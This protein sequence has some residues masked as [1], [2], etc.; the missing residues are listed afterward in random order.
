MSRPD[1]AEL[2]VL[3]CLDYVPISE[4][5]WFDTDASTVAYKRKR[6]AQ[7]FRER[8]ADKREP[9]HALD[10]SWRLNFIDDKA[11]DKQCVVS[12]GQIELLRFPS[13]FLIWG[14]CI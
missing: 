13:S 14:D 8:V 3:A 2:R 5:N 12:R 6:A 4:G 7:S 9:V 10:P 11:V 1:R